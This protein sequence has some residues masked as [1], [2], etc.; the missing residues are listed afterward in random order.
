[1]NNEGVDEKEK[2]VLDKIKELQRLATKKLMRER[3]EAER[4]GHLH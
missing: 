4:Q 1:M 2:K 3:R